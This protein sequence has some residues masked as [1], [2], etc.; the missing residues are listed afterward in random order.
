MSVPFNKNKRLHAESKRLHAGAF[1]AFGKPFST[2]KG[3]MK[4]RAV[5]AKILAC[6]LCSLLLPNSVISKNRENIRMGARLYVHT[7]VF[8]RAKAQRLLA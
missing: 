1:A 6:I 8:A 4:M 2:G 3:T 5:P 7:H